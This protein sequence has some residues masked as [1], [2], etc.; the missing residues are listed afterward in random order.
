MTMPAQTRDSA[1]L[2]QLFFSMNFATLEQQLVDFGPTGYYMLEAFLLQ[3]LLLEAKANQQELIIGGHATAAYYDAYAE[4]GFGEIRRPLAIEISFSGG[5]AKLE[6][7]LGRYLQ[8]RKNHDEALLVISMRT[9]SPAAR[10]LF[11]T[12]RKSDLL[13]LWEPNEIQTLIDK[14]SAEAEELSRKLFSS[15]LQMVVS[16]A[17]ED[18]KEKR[19]NIIA[20]VASQFKNGRFS[21]F[22]GA[23]VSSSAGIPDWNTLLNSL[24]V[25]MLTSD[26]LTDGSSDDEHIRSIVKRLREVDGPSALMLAR[27]IRRGLTSGSDEERGTF[28]QAVTA[29]LYSLRDQR[30]ALRS[31]LI[32]AIA[33]LC[34][35]TRTG[36]KVQSVLTYNFDDLIERELVER[37]VRFKS[38]FEEMDSANQEELPIYHVHGFLPEDRAKYQNLERSTLVFSEE[39]YH[40]IYSEPYHWSNLIQLSNLRDTTCLMVGLSLTD[41]NLRRLLEIASK[42]AET[43]R[44]FAFLRRL[45]FEKFSSIGEKSVVR[46]PAAMVKQF[47]DRHHNLNEEVLRELG[48]NVIWFEDYEEIPKILLELCNLPGVH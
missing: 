42:S 7:L 25:S 21:L 38:I 23:G 2:T 5:A 40:K 24:F 19:K 39:G 30:F 10:K 27:Y 29:Q 44:H 45:D 48:V 13:Y 46:A 32:R 3:L 47:L 1:L 26:G 22:L 15:R 31:T 35:P 8:H 17:P 14:H 41:P 12:A 4:N 37:S 18:W 6:S 33:A 20:D 34:T 28:V 36:A 11:D 43:P 16:R 9:L